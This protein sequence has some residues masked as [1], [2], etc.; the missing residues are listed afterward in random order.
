VAGEIGKI[1]RYRQI[2]RP[3]FSDKSYNLDYSPSVL[4]HWFDLHALQ[5][6]VAGLAVLCGISAVLSLALGRMATLRFGLAILFVAG[7]VGLVAYSRGPL[8][9][10]ESTCHYRFLKSELAIDGCAHAQTGS[11]P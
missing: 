10:A 6:T 7:T 5:L 1:S 9:R 3:N 4:P 2:G 11:Q 8:Q